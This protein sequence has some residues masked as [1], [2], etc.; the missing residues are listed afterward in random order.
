MCPVHW[1][2]AVFLLLDSATVATSAQASSALTAGEVAAFERCVDAPDTC[3]CQHVVRHR[4]LPDV[5]CRSRRSMDAAGR[6]LR[7]TWAVLPV[8]ER[9]PQVAVQSGDVIRSIERASRSWLR[10]CARGTRPDS[11]YTATATTASAEHAILFKWEDLDKIRN[12]S[13]SLRE[14]IACF[15]P[16]LSDSCELTGGWM[17]FAR[18]PVVGV[19]RGELVDPE[20]A[21]WLT[22]GLSHQ[23]S[24][25]LPLYSHCLDETIMHE[26]GHTL[27]LDNYPDAR[28]MMCAE[29]SEPGHPREPAAC[30]CTFLARVYPAP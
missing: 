29:L 14:A 15:N 12:S 13:F 16:Y 7:L 21:T 28:S 18:D 27:G 1:S 4:A 6:Y 11:A 22:H 24:A 20:P 8:P 17:Y 19:R 25:T 26:F 9:S 10:G 30:D 2:A 3:G 5:Y 23:N